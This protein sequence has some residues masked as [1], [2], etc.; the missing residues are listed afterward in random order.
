MCPAN[1]TTTSDDE[2]RNQTDKIT[3]RITKM[4]EQDLADDPYAQEAHSDRRW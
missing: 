4:I 1:S 3:G 2:A